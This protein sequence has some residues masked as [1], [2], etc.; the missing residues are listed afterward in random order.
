M[1]QF[2]RMMDASLQTA[3]NGVFGTVSSVASNVL[4]L[5]DSP[6]GARLLMD[7][8]PIQ[9]YD[10]TLTTNRGSA[11][12][13]AVQNGLGQTQTI[14]LNAAPGGTTA[15]DLVVVAGVS[16]ASPTFI[17]GLPLN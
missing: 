12:I 6:F 2:R 13:T 1:K 10:S 7:Q 16:G 14:T 9:I 3:G 15:T 17:Y 4:T 11:T 8:Q 5:N